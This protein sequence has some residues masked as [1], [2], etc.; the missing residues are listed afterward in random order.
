[1]SWTKRK[2]EYQA[3]A[4]R[5]DPAVRLSVKDGWFWRTLAAFLSVVT[6]GQVSR[7]Q[8]LEGCATSVGPVVCI[9]AGWG[10]LTS[11]FLAHEARHVTQS[12]WFGFGVHPW[13]GFPL[14]CL[15]YL[16][17]PL[18]IG[19]S[20]CRFWFELDADR[21]AFKAYVDELYRAGWLAGE[22]IPILQQAA[23]TRAVVV[24]GPDYA[25]AWPRSWALRGYQKMA[26]QVMIEKSLTSAESYQ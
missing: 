4:A 19:L 21:K 9:P 18:P 14:F 6:F 8:F 16:L 11:D 17:L 20:W 22:I 7:K 26:N 10:N 13:V 3:I 1:M 24:S 2:E 25:W 12:R 23:N 15:A 5:F